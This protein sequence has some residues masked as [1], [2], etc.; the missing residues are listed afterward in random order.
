MHGNQTLLQPT[1][2]NSNQPTNGLNENLT[3]HLL[4]RA[5]TKCTIVQSFLLQ[6]ASNMNKTRKQTATNDAKTV[7]V[8][9]NALAFSHSFFEASNILVARHGVQLT[10]ICG[11]RLL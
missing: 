6:L 5:S 2:I 1:R 3:L 8:M 11:A 9:K 10:N 7:Q 4:S